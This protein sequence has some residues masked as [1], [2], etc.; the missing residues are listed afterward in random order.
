VELNQPRTAAQIWEGLLEEDDN[1]AEVYYHL[2][3][4]Y[5]IFN[6][7]AAKENLEK[8]ITL[9]KRCGDLPFLKEAQQLMEEM[10]NENIVD[11]QEN[12]D[13]DDDDD[14]DDEDKSKDQNHMEL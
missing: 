3:I 14:D 8:A 7:A 13:D 11:D 4:A 1:I 12:E 6:S 10:K 9:L 5:R 2:S